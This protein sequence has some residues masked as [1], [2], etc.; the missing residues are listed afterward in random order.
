MRSA[1]FGTRAG[2]SGTAEGLHTDDR[3]D[4][5]AIHVGVADRRGLIYLP[6]KGFQTGLYAERQA[7]IAGADGCQDLLDVVGSIAHHVQY[8]A[9][10]L[11]RELCSA[12]ELDE[13]RRDEAAAG[14][15]I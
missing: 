3:A 11:A 10:F 6:P 9:K 13:M 15:R 12:S 5:V 4:H 1:G 14:V 7:V 8:R 2:K